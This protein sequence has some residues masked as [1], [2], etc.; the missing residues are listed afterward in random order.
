MKMRRRNTAPLK[1]A[2]CPRVRLYR[3]NSDVIDA[4]QEALTVVQK[5][6]DYAPVNPAHEI[7]A[8]VAIQHRI[9]QARQNEIHTRRAQAAAR[10]E[11]MVA[12]WTLHE[13][14]LGV[15]AQVLAQYGPNSDAVAAVGLK[16]RSKRRRS[17][18]GKNQSEAQ[19]TS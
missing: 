12:E 17:S 2:I 7:E 9:E 5:L 4:D 16:K 11:L 3:L 15:K 10:D 19:P 18:R 14:M 1:E 6:N 8:L 13:A